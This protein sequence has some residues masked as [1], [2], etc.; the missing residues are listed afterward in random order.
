MEVF[1]SGMNKKPPA[2]SSNSEGL[3]KARYNFESIHNRQDDA[4]NLSTYKHENIGFIYCL[5]IIR[6]ARNVLWQKLHKFELKVVPVNGVKCIDLTT[7]PLEQLWCEEYSFFPRL[8]SSSIHSFTT[9][10]KKSAIS[11]SSFIEPELSLKDGK[12]LY[13]MS[14]SIYASKLNKGLSLEGDNYLIN[15]NV[16]LEQVAN[17]DLTSLKT[18][19]TL[20]VFTFRFQNFS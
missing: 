19:I 4:I 3:A 7:L 6:L 5:Y 20:R 15:V 10:P 8:C 13:V 11:V 16:D 18:W 2:C 1:L 17:L 9:D 12:K 14:S